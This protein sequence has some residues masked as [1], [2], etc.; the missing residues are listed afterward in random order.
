VFSS[1]SDRAR[2]LGKYTPALMDSD[3]MDLVCGRDKV[4]G[5]EQVPDVA[6]RMLSGQVRGR[7]VVSPK[8]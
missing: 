1:K 5:L 2:V 8:L 3:K 7:Y 6:G 4:L